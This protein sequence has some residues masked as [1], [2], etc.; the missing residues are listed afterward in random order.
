[1]IAKRTGAKC[2]VNGEAGCALEKAGVP[3]EQI[4]KVAGGETL[5]LGNGVIVRPWPALQCVDSTIAS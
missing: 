3:P 4:I 2:V 5:D 1:M